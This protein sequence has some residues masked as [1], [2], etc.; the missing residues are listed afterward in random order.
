[1]DFY[2]RAMEQVIRRAWASQP[3]VVLEGP[4]ASGKTRLAEMIVGPERLYR[5]DDSSILGVAQASPR[6][7][8]ESL[9]PGS[10]IDEAQ[11]L[12]GVSVEVKRIADVT[13]EPGRLLLT[14]SHR[15]S[16][17]ELGGSDPLAGR[18]RRLQLLPLLQSELSGE[19]RDFVSALF[20][21]DP[22]SWRVSATSQPA[23]KERM[24]VGGFPTAQRIEKRELN[25]WGVDYA[26]SIISSSKTG[27]DVSRF[28]RLYR[29][30][31][32]TSGTPQNISNFGR[33]NDLDNKTVSLYLSELQEMF[34]VFDVPA[35]VTIDKREIKAPRLF[36]VDP[37]LASA[38]LTEGPATPEEGSIFE[39]F[40]A[41]ELQRL[42]NVSSTRAN[43]LWWKLPD[44]D[45]K[46]SGANEVDLVV[47]HEDGRIVAIEVKSARESKAEHFNG[48]RAMRQRY[49]ERFHRGVVLHCGTQSIRHE[50]SLWAMPFSAL[51]EVGDLFKS[52]APAGRSALEVAV[53]RVIAVDSEAEAQK[54][55]AS[56]HIIN[57]AEPTLSLV[58]EY[59]AKVG[60]ETAAPSIS[61]DSAW[62]TLPGKGGD[63]FAPKLGLGVKAT[64]NGGWDWFVSLSFG[65][66]N[67]TGEIRIADLRDLNEQRAAMDQLLAWIAEYFEAIVAF[68]RA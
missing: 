47:E 3:V 9:P 63:A 31:A 64:A 51:W 12:P 7:W 40:V 25:D 46:A 27:R 44:A 43:L 50:E 30:L 59:L 48:I 16:R 58:R 55:L 45:R 62:L 8:V 36:V 68:V 14:G 49:G 60:I 56:E 53:K 54:R 39:T 37:L 13:G 24:M 66:T 26:S 52:P 29:W 23:M 22:A 2:P 18:V 32:A 33:A 4:R 10:A 35:L 34:L 6:A 15:L 67:E 5:L 28:L 19:P 20:D 1:M 61:N 42:L 11:L 17:T 57:F 21:T 65:R 38:R 41:C